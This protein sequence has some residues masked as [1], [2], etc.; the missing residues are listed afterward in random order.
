[1]VQCCKCNTRNDR[2]DVW[3]RAVSVTQGMTGED[4]WFRAVS[5]PQRMTGEDVWFS[6]VS[7][8]QGMTG[9]M[10]GSVL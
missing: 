1:M 8:T 3:F 6:A 7:V 10:C 4:V 9:K 2:E 5:V